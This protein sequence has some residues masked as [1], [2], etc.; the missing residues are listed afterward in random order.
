MSEVRSVELE[1]LRTAAASSPIPK[2]I[3]RDSFLQRDLIDLISLNSP[4]SDRRIVKNQTPISLPYAALF[5]I[6]G[7]TGC[8]QASKVAL[9]Q[10]EQA[11][12][13]IAAG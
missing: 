4:T 12:L 8:V 9:Q 5:Y 2:I 1:V 11:K 6:I 7:N 10:I 3:S 13:I